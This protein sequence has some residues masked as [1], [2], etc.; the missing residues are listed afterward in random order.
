M[1]TAPQ[2]LDAERKAHAETKA[3][4]ER[5]E[6]FYANALDLLERY[7]GQPALEKM[8]DFTEAHDAK[9]RADEMD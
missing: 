8:R 7:G 9:E 4:L 2:A 1:T 5:H 6:I 3:K